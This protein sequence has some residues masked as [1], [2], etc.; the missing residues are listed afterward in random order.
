MASLKKINNIVV[1]PLDIKYKAK[2]NFKGKDLFNIWCP[3]MFILAKKNSGKTTTIYFT[4][5]KCSGK[6][7][8]FIFIVSTLDKDPIWNAIVDKLGEERCA[9]FKS[10]YDDDD[11]NI[12]QQ[13]MDDNNSDKIAPEEVSQSG[14]GGV[15]LNN[16]KKN[17][18]QIG[19]G[20][21]PTPPAPKVDTWKYNYPKFIIVMDDLGD[22]MR[23]KSVTQLLKTNRH[24]DAMTIISSQSLNDLDKPARLNLDY[25][26]IFPKLPIEKLKMIH[27]DLNLST[28]FDDFLKKYEEA[29]KEKYNFLY[30]GR[31]ESEEEY[32]KN[33]NEAFDK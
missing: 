13:F 24:F 9:T 21:P 18:R 14:G 6:H 25:M 5:E 20:E 12:I 11:V 33:F 22:T 32:R 28:E 4:L 27:Q 1:K 29:T 26:L 7:T 15:P 30:I 16:F 10:L 3:N 8:K 2:K 17:Q 23:D 31:S 19:S